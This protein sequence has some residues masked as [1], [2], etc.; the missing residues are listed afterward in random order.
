MTTSR[1]VGAVPLLMSAVPAHAATGSGGSAAEAGPIALL[2]VAAAIAWHFAAGRWQKTH[3]RH[4]FIRV[5][6]AHALVPVLTRLHLDRAHLHLLRRR[7][8][9]LYRRD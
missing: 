1:F 7:A 5:M 8:R 4:V 6:P 9:R 3:G 2:G